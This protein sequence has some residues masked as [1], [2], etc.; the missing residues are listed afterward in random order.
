MSLKL[1]M[2][3]LACWVAAILCGF[4]AVHYLSQG[5]LFDGPAHDPRVSNFVDGFQYAT[6]AI[7]LALFAVPLTHLT[8]SK[9]HRRRHRIDHDDHHF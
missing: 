9:K 8:V 7:L 1:S 6:V 4:L 5:V 2:W 3:A